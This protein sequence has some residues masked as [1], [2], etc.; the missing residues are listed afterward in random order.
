MEME[1]DKIMLHLY[2]S[3]FTKFIREHTN[4]SSYSD[5][6]YFFG[7]NE[8]QKFNVS[9]K[10]VAAMYKSAAEKYSMIDFGN[11]PD[12]KGDI[13]RIKKIDEIQETIKT[14]EEIMSKTSAGSGLK[15]IDTVKK[16]MEILRSYKREFSTG[17]IQDKAMVVMTYNTIVLSI[18]V[19]LDY[20]MKVVIDYITT[21]NATVDNSRKSFSNSQT[22]VVVDNLNKF[23]ASANNGE[24][25][26]FF[27]SVLSKDN[28][29]GPIGLASV[30]GV[31]IGA[32]VLVAAI[33]IIPITRE[34]I[35]F[36]YNLRMNISE[37][38]RRQ[39][40]FLEINVAELRAGN[41]NVNNRA[42]VIKRQEKK[43]E[44]FRKTADKFE[45]D[46]NKANN[47]TKKELHQKISTD[48]LKAS[49]NSL[50]DN[51]GFGLL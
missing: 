40:D 13:D 15:E 25:T 35:Y 24:L 8:T 10:L 2:D 7:L 32:A 34:L 14:I 11:I 37:F 44:Q 20:C 36:L 49:V 39:A 23:I 21:P 3:T 30:S 22:D 31:A 19:E 41:G 17:F 9:D 12:S 50:D 26:K 46:F 33:A 29:I 16:T 27:D 5:R 1:N 45:V 42:K 43:I 48:T 28:F 47:K 18:Y 51:N 6:N 38:F 4:I